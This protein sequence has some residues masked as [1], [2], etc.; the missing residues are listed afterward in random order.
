LLCFCEWE[1][2]F[3]GIQEEFPFFVIF[4]KIPT[5]KICQRRVPF[6]QFYSIN[7]VKI[8]SL[9]AVFFQATCPISGPLVACVTLTAVIGQ[10]SSLRTSTAGSGPPIR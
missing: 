2:R 5:V 6:P 8:N 9:N 7:V 10:I 1:N 3:Q 4:L